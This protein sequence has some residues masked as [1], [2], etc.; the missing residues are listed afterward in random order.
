MTEEEATLLGLV[1]FID[2]YEFGDNGTC[3]SLR[4]MTRI[5][6]V[7]G[8]VSLSGR[9]RTN[10]SKLSRIISVMFMGRTEM[11]RNIITTNIDGDVTNNSVENLMIETRKEYYERT[12]PDMTRKVCVPV[13]KR[14]YM[15]KS[16]KNQC[17]SEW[18]RSESK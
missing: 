18:Q 11:S 1:P 8:T 17:M 7:N 13:S 3:L 16:Y 10:T 5:G 15:T 6:N 12:E 14:F 4:D 2:Y 9:I